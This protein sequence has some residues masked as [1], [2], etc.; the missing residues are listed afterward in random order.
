[1]SSRQH[2]I[3][4][5]GAGVFCEGL[6]MVRHSNAHGFYCFKKGHRSLLAEDGTDAHRNLLDDQ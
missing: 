3:G 5:S 6:R 2:I 4:K 1:M